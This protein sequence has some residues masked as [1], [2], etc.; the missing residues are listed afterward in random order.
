M[1]IN[2]WIDKYEHGPADVRAAVTGLSEEQVKSFPV[3]G[4]WS[5]QQIVMHLADSDLIG[6]DRL[7]RIVAMDNAVLQSYDETQFTK[8]LHYHDQSLPDALD[9]MEINSRQT[10]RILRKLPE[11]AF[12]RKG[13]HTEVGAISLA[14]MLQRIANHVDHH[15]KFIHQKRKLLLAA[16]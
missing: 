1:T 6:A 13:M 8:S 5:I 14:E 16:K 12:A 15:L 3:P 7:K 4:T 11:S 10:A 2:E 9:L